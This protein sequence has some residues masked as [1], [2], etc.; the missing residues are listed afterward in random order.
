MKIISITPMTLDGE[1]IVV[2]LAEY[3]HA[4]PVFPAD[5]KAADLAS[6]LDAWQKNQDAVDAINA[7]ALAAPKPPKAEVAKEMK[8]LIGKDIIKGK[9]VP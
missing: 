8:D 1:K 9:V 3:P 4:Q 2:T 7:A 5:T 6:L